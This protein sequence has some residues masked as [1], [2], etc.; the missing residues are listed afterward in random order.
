MGKGARKESIPAFFSLDSYGGNL[1][2]RQP[3]AEGPRRFRDAAAAP[4][5]FQLDILLFVQR[6]KIPMR[7]KKIILGKFDSVVGFVRPVF[8]QPP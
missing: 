8:F 5:F 7:E 2:A 4:D 6:E 1:F 3:A